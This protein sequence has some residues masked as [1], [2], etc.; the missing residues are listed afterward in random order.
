[1]TFPKWSC[2]FP[3][4]ASPLMVVMPSIHKHICDKSIQPGAQREPA[5]VAAHVNSTHQVP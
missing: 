5:A 3:N 1:M 4:A 2:L